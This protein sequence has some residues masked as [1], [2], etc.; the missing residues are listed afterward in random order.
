MWAGKCGNPPNTSDTRTSLAAINEGGFYL[1][2]EFLDTVK[3]GN[4]ALV[5]AGGTDLFVVKYSALGE[6]EWSLRLGGSDYDYNQKVICD[7]AGNVIVAGYFYGTIQ[8]GPDQ[9][10]SYGSQDLFVAKYDAEGQFQWSFRAGGPMADYISGLSLDSQDNVLFA[11]YFYDELSLGDTTVLSV[12]SSDIFLAKLSPEGAFSWVA[13]AG[14]SSSD[15]TRSIACDD[16]DNILLTASFYYDITLEDTLLTTVDPVGNVVAK[17]QPDG[18]LIRAFQLNGTYLTSDI[19][20]AAGLAGDFYVSG[21]FSEDIH[22]G[23]TTFSAGEFNQD[24]YLAKYNAEGIFQWAR[25]AYSIASDQVVGLVTDSYGNVSIT[26][27]H[28]DT[29][30][31]EQ[32]VLPYHLCCGSRE[33]FIVSYS[34]AGNVNWGEQI[35]G[36]RSNVHAL[37]MSG[38]D[39]VILSGQFTEEVAFGPLQLSYFEGFKNYI[40]CLQTGVFTRV[41]DM[42]AEK[43][44][45]IY[46]N[47]AREKISLVFPGDEDQAEYQILTAGG[48]QVASGI[49]QSHVA[50]SIDKL[51]P[52]LYFISTAPKGGQKSVQPFLII[53]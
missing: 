50:I 36:T 21:N 37:A 18:Q 47:P 30:H 3:F 2:G 40:T 33:I 12:R 7:A 14:G 16:D 15:Q 24:V 31:F 52:G 22:F 39:E 9:H 23:N 45:L 32:L 11:G 13:V 51:S 44:I 26:G 35:T 10:E 38:D 8:I 20:V 42:Q 43:S 17:Y 1:T 28:L 4:K 5:S 53:H 19:F 27:H 49:T 46:P 34:A 29:M 48:K 41:N 25:H 6:A